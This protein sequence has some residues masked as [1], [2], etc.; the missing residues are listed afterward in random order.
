MSCSPTSPNARCRIP[1]TRARP[2]STGISSSFTHRCAITVSTTPRTSFAGTFSYWAAIQPF[3]RISRRIIPACPPMG[4]CR[5]QIIAH[6][7]TRAGCGSRPMVRKRQARSAMRSTPATR[8]DQA[9]HLRDNSLRATGA[10]V[11][12]PCFTPDG[13]TFFISVQHPGDDD[14]ST[15]DKPSTRWPDFDDKMPPRPAVVAVCRKDG[16][17]IGA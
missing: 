10:E 1:R 12:G 3:A 9:G 13:T 15:F 7:T 11:C 5:A 4:G 6:L 16:G 14:G 2:I 8:R 17:K